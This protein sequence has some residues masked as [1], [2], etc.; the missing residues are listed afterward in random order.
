[1]KQR[2]TLSQLLGIEHSILLAPM[3]LISNTKMVVA[4][5]SC[6]CTAA[7]PAL[8]YRT[9]K[10]LHEAILEIRR[11]TSK[12]FGFNL[13]VNKSNLKY[14]SQLKTLLDLKVDFIITSLGNP[15]DVIASCKPLGIKVFCDVTD[16]EYA[17]KVEQLGADAIIAVN[18]QAGG[19]CGHLPAKE[20]I[21]QLFQSTSLPIVSAG[22]IRN[23]SDVKQM[24]EW[25][26][27]GVSV[28][29]I[30]IA[31]HESDV[32]KE[33]KQAMIQYGSKDIV[34][35]TKLTGS[36]L[37]VIN[38]AYVKKIGTKANFWEWLF[39][40]SS[41]LKKYAKLILAWQGMSKVKKS[42]FKASY[43]NVWCAGPSIESVKSIRS[44]KDVLSGL[45]QADN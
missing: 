22:G 39:N 5:L 19:H 1:M 25:G 32:S 42:A 37:T 26:A 29:T 9:K 13:I 45:I 11:A 35:S 40:N 4:A 28:G 23:N 34:K 10:E 27:S 36:A 18:S 6:G 33:Y 15:K 21:S 16:V 3:F 41:I 14:K 30:F 31:T 8:N 12:P 24:M 17:Q 38:T 44:V 20:L 7:I 2:C 43:Q